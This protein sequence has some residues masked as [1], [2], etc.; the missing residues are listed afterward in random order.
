M[1]QDAIY[2]GQVAL[3]ILEFDFHRP[4]KNGKCNREN[5]EEKIIEGIL[6]KELEPM[7]DK[8]VEIICELIDTMILELGVKK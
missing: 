8:D 6:K 2:H 7:N 5:I 4:F 3:D 1:L